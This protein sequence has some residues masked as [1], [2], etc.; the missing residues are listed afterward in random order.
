MKVVEVDISAYKL[1]KDL[2]LDFTKHNLE[3]G[4][5][6]ILKTDKNTIFIAATILVVVI[7]ALSYYYKKSQHYAD[8]V[9]RRVFSEDNLEEIEAEVEKNFGNDIVFEEKENDDWNKFN[10][11][12]LSKAYGENEPEYDLSMIKEP[13]PTYKGESR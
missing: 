12:N 6:L 4:D 8:T 5:Q 7:I 1:P 13:N 3:E 11:N 9:L 2:A 10:I